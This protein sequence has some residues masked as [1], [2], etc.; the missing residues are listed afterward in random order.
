METGGL[1]DVS[2]NEFGQVG[3]RPALRVDLEQKLQGQTGKPDGQNSP[4]EPSHGGG[5][6]RKRQNLRLP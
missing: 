2:G 5:R 6:R 3:R 4:D 1:L